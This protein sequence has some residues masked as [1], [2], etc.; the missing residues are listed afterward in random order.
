MSNVD[1]IFSSVSK[2][3]YGLSMGTMWQHISIECAEISD[4]YLLRKEVFFTLIESLLKQG[5]IK[6]ASNGEFL[7]GTTEEQIQELIAAW[8]P[9]PSDNQDDDLDE[10]G[11]WFLVK[12]PAG[13]VWLTPDGKELWT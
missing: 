10:Y 12:A 13:I 6:L 4:N 3:A 2:S 11:I 7:S 9:F 8:P 5:K 1:K